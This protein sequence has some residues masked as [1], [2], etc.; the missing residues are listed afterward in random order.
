MSGWGAVFALASYITTILVIFVVLMQYHQQAK[1]NKAQV[2]AAAI[3][4]AAV[5][6]VLVVLVT[7]RN[8]VSSIMGMDR[9]TSPPIVPQYVQPTI[10]I[11]GNV[12]RSSRQAAGNG[13]IQSADITT[14]NSPPN[15]LSISIPATRPWTPTGIIVEEGQIVTVRAAGKII[16]SDHNPPMSPDGTGKACW[17]NPSIHYW[18]FPAQ[19]LSCSSLIGKIGDGEPFE[20]GSSQQFRA[21]TLGLLSLGVNDNWFADNHGSW[22]VTIFR[23][24]KS[25]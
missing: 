22:E 1:N 3:F 24:E 18:H 5:I 13:S 14:P 12:T 2:W 16:V 4:G 23:K 25:Q 20:V 11:G 21:T 19:N 6:A 8:E 17:P 15:P 7:H 9:P 10:V